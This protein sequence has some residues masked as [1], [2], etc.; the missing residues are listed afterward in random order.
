M[1]EWLVHVERK[2]LAM[3]EM[4]SLAGGRPLFYA[5]YRHDLKFDLEA[6]SSLEANVE[7]YYCDDEPNAEAI[8]KAIALRH[9]GVEIYICKTVKRAFSAPSEV[10]FSDVTEK[11][12][13]PR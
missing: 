6:E 5:P 12:V 9:P 11:G 13:L 10:V 4:R 2:N 3:H 7:T 8:A 1:K